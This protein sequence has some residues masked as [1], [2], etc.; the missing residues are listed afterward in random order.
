MTITKNV[1]LPLLMRVHH[2]IRVC[3]GFQVWSRHHRYCLHMDNAPA[4]RSDLVQEGL[5]AVHWPVI[6]H[7]P[8]SPDLSPCDFFLFP[9]LKRR[10]R[11]V[12]FH[13]LNSLKQA[14]TAELGAIPKQVWEDCFDNWL[15]RCEK[16]LA[17]DGAYFEGMKNLGV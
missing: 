1:F 16:C 9:Y 8:Y 10:L 2:Q 5:Q 3:R 7:P 15:K 17:A 14:I 4:H 6:S 12:N 13:T 11:A